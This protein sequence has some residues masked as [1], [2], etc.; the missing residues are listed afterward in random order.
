MDSP[1][2]VARPFRNHTNKKLLAEQLALLYL[3]RVTQSLTLTD[4]AGQIGPI[5]SVRV[6]NR[7]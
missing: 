7:N 5:R 6:H 4:P 2:L 1:Q 3:F